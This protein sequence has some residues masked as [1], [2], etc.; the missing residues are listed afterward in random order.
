[1][2]FK[3]EGIG[4]SNRSHFTNEMARF[5]GSEAAMFSKGEDAA[6][7]KVDDMAEK[8]VRMSYEKSKTEHKGLKAERKEIEVQVKTQ[9]ESLKKDQ[10]QYKDASE[11]LTAQKDALESRSKTEGQTHQTAEQKAAFDREVKEE[12][13]KIKEQERFLDDKATQIEEKD[14][15]L[16]QTQEKKKEY[17]KKEDKAKKK[18]SAKINAASVLKIKKDISNELG[19]GGANTG[20]AFHDGKGGL[21]GTFLQVINPMHYV[22]MLLAKLGALLAPYVVIFATISII[23]VVIFA[24]LFDVLSPIVKVTEALNNI[25]SFFNGDNTFVNTTLDQATIDQIV[26]D[27]GCNETQEATIRYALSKV[28]YPYSQAQRAS[29]NAYDCSSLAYY[30]W[31]AAGVDISGGGRYPPTASAEAQIMERT[32]KA[33]DN[34]NISNLEPGDLI[35]YGGDSNGRYKGIYH[36]AIYVGNGKAVEALNTQYGVVYQNLRTKNAIMVVRPS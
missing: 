13:A 8:A 1:M 23:V 15:K 17:K 9:K 7:G 6:V 20:D 36:V 28:G 26:A 33:L 35:F 4:F 21:V 22:K 31:E 16:K 34:N 24:I 18:Q 19:G 5:V 12:R 30:A 10:E 11:K 2:A 32:G 25:V 29:G 27:S 3:E 14:F